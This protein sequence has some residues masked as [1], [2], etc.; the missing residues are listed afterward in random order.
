M[1]WCFCGA[2]VLLWC[3]GATVLLWCYGAPRVLLW[4][5]GAPVVLNSGVCVTIYGSSA[6]KGFAKE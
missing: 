5:Y 3:Y 4:C 2:M 6:Q 1:L